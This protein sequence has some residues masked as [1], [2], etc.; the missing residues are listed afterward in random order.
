M[1]IN[2]EASD[3]VAPPAGTRERP[4]YTFEAGRIGLNLRLMSP[5]ETIRGTASVG[6]GLSYD[7]V[8]F[9]AAGEQICAE[10]ACFDAEGVDPFLFADIGLELDFG[11]ALVGLALEGYFQS[12]RGLDLPEDDDADLY[13]PRALI[14]L[15]GS[16]RVGYAFW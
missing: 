3:E 1:N 11:G 7:S 6:A 15:G 5:G 12:S 13:E 10:G 8:R 16:V 4:E 14:H 2:V 9:N